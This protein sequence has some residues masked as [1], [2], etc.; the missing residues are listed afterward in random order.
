MK[1]IKKNIKNVRK[2]DVHNAKNTWG[3]ERKLWKITSRPAVPKKEKQLNMLFTGL[4]RSVQG[5]SVSSAGVNKIYLCLYLIF[6]D[7]QL[8]I[9]MYS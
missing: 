1:T 7:T 3:I 4:G 9:I 6:L 5:K 8:H 2:E